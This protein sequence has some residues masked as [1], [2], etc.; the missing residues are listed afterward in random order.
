[1]EQIFTEGDFAN[2]MTGTYWRHK[3]AEFLKRALGSSFSAK[4]VPEMR[5]IVVYHTNRGHIPNKAVHLIVSFGYR[6]YFAKE[7]W[8]FARREEIV[9]GLWLEKGFLANSANKT[10]LDKYPDEYMRKPHEWDW[11]RFIDAIKESSRLPEFLIYPLQQ[12]NTILGIGNQDKWSEIILKDDQLIDLTSDFEARQITWRKL[13]DLIN[14]WNKRGREWCN[15]ILF[16]KIRGKENIL[17][18]DYKVISQI[19]Y[20]FRSLIPIYNTCVPPEYKLP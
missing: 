20:T 9:F 14:S 16:K 8:D 17:S 11:T 5:Q 19:V 3:L 12:P 2:L 15:I 4:S 6:N 10:D 7:T 13:L 1:M 18:K